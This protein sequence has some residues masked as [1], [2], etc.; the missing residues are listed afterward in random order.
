MFDWCKQTS[1]LPFRIYRLDWCKHMFVHF[2]YFIDIKSLKQHSVKSLVN[3]LTFLN[4]SK[5]SFVHCLSLKI[6]TKNK[7]KC[8]G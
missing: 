7:Q 1:T 3:S 6:K 4:K 2:K 5:M 8:D